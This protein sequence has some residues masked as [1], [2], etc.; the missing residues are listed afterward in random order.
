MYPVHKSPSLLWRGIL[1]I[2]LMAG[3]YL[4]ALGISLGLF[5]LSYTTLKEGDHGS[6]FLVAICIFSGGAILW[7]I[8]PRRDKFKAPGE[9]ITEKQH[10][11]LFELIRKAA[12]HAQ[13]EV[14]EEVYL[15]HD[16]NAW[17]GERGGTLGWGSRRVMGV[18]LPLL[19]VL[20]SSELYAV[21]L[22][23][24]GHF[25]GGDTKIGPWVWKTRSAIAR[26]VESLGDTFF[27]LPFVWY[28]KAFLRVT[29]AISRQQELA[30]DGLA[31][32]GAGAESLVQAL[33]RLHGDGVLYNSYWQQEVLPILDRGYRPPIFSGFSDYLKVPEIDGFVRRRLEAEIAEDKSDPYDTHPC[34]RDRLASLE[35]LPA[36]E[37]LYE[38]T[39]A[40]SLLQS[41]LAEAELPML[42]FLSD[43]ATAAK[44]KPILWTDVGDTIWR[45]IWESE[46]GR[47][48][49]VLASLTIG[50]AP[51]LGNSADEF[52]GKLGVKTGSSAD[53]AM[54]AWRLLGLALAT[55]LAEAGW[56]TLT[57]PGQEVELLP[58][59]GIPKDTVNP[60]AMAKKLVLGETTAS[61]WQAHCQKLGIATLPLAKPA[62]TPPPPSVAPMFSK[63]LEDEG[64][65]P[66]K[67]PPSLV[68]INGVGLCLYGKRDI[69]GNTYVATRW[70]CLVFIP[71]LAID[72]WRVASAASGGW[73]FLARVRLSKFARNMNLAIA[74]LAVVGLLSLVWSAHTE[75]P[76]Y[77]A[78][79]KMKEADKLLAGGKYAAAA[80]AYA[81][82]AKDG[83]FPEASK[84]GFHTAMTEALRDGQPE[85][86]LQNFRILLA[87]PS[88]VRKADPAFAD[89]FKMAMDCVDRYE[90]E[91]PETALE[92]LGLAKRQ[93]PAGET[94]LPARRIAILRRIVQAKPGNIPLAVE[95]AL[96]LD[97]GGS[98]DEAIRLLKPIQGQL[99]STEGARLLGQHYL[100]NN[101][102]REAYPLLFTYVKDHLEALRNLE[103]SYEIRLKS[104]QDSAIQE[105]R[106][107]RADQSFYTEYEAAGKERQQQMVNNFII[108]KIEQDG[109][110]RKLSEEMKKDGDT[111]N[112]ALD[113][114]ILQLRRAQ[115]MDDP[116]QRRLE[117]EAAE[118]TF[119]SIR[120]FASESDEYQMFLGQVYCWLGRPAEAQPLFDKLLEKHK[121][122]CEI[123]ESL[124][125]VY[126]TLGD[127]AKARSLLEE[128]YGAAK[129]PKTKYELAAGRASILKDTDDQIAWLEKCDPQQQ[130][131]QIELNAAKG[132]KALERGDLKAAAALMQKAI[133]G[134]RQLP[135][136]TAT[137]N[138]AALVYFN[139]FKAT[140]KPEYQ[141]Q[142]MEMVKEAVS[143][144]PDNTT[145]I[146]NTIAALWPQAVRETLGDAVRPEALVRG[147]S[148]DALAQLYD[149]EPGSRQVTIRFHAS[150]P[151]KM[152]EEFLNRLLLISPKDVDLY[153]L[154]IHIAI[155][156]K[157]AEALQRLDERMKNAGFDMET[158]RTQTLEAYNDTDKEGQMRQQRAAT[159]KWFL[160]MLARPEIVAHPPTH[161]FL[162][163][164]WVANRISAAAYGQEVDPAKLVEAAE[165]ADREHPCSLSRNTLAAAHMFAAETRLASQSPEFAAIA[166]R[167]RRTLNSSQLFAL[168][169]SRQDPLASAIR[170][171]PS[172]KKGAGLYQEARQKFPDWPNLEQWGILDSAD[173]RMTAEMAARFQAH[174]LAARCVAMSYRM[175]PWNADAIVDQYLQCRLLGNAAG[176]ASIYDQAVKA[177]VALP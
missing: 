138:N 172:F 154:A 100:K 74:G 34:L 141:R 64:A 108:A 155:N 3:F 102:A 45:P 146:G 62:D 135:K 35:K 25:H 27:R 177:G 16:F 31:A 166:K 12:V 134:Y 66:V 55:S 32:Q 150:E 137:L 110:L 120:G 40:S 39:P 144:A 65:R 162:L 169:L 54:A 24:F 164:G 171:D 53:A 14:P 2:V 1:A 147:A 69:R 79:H 101:Q 114:G 106:S 107:G 160:E 42:A 60:F 118:K 98:G 111:V 116:A 4:L 81:E 59:G 37:H 132:E 22:H 52:A 68:T 126:R 165:T 122:S 13:Q 148:I 20:T 112:L 125:Q 86:A 78:R 130:H 168:L 92:F 76:E 49:E 5:Y 36:R 23:E 70:L 9:R 143:M 152:A 140:G 96:A 105:L 80:Q 145:L 47:I 71:V 51:T 97:Q 93:A 84:A 159:E 123:L 85:T 119:L 163:N 129:N 173:P 30:A 131:T 29:H 104:L 83:R 176:A 142:G 115:E 10:P 157:D 133:D 21:I 136:N 19:Q 99:G 175:N 56:R 57:L 38:T 7:S 127:N 77:Q 17:V 67:D 113:L 6:V 109:T 48:R 88:N 75:S 103:R 44:L 63:E 153:A 117:L 128:A 170:A 151:A 95:L 156:K 73:Y 72:A 58:A 82:V 18:G 33:K 41:P 91:H 28:A 61:E 174:P 26:T 43:Q 167:T 11:R 139:L 8:L 15:C 149:D 121:R 124:A 87:I 50:Q 94:G 161:Q 46:M 89:P 90:S 158:I